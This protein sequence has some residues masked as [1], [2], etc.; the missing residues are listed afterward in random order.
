MSPWSR[1]GA[2]LRRHRGAI[3]RCCATRGLRSLARPSSHLA[4]PPGAVVAKLL[5]VPACNLA[6]VVAVSWALPATD[7]LV[8]L[9]MTVL[10]ASP[11]AMNM[12]A[13][14]PRP[15]AQTQPACPSTPEPSHCYVLRELTI[16]HLAASAQV[17][18]RGCHGA[19]RARDG[20]AALLAV[21]LRGAHD[22]H[23]CDGS[24]RVVCPGGLMRA[25]RASTVPYG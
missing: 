15:S 21:R 23:F 8:L 13:T 24:V 25:T 17:D 10:G 6:L 11:A 14:R 20:H 4:P 9:I 1:R 5:L 2:V 3:E 7:P 22:D 16:A 19:R 12:R 18:D